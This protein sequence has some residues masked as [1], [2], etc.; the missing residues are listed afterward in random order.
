VEIDSSSAPTIH[1]HAL[2]EPEL[3]QKL[4]TSRAGLTPAQAAERLREF[5]PNVLPT[6]KPPSPFVI[7]LRQLLSP[8]IYILIAAGVLAIVMGDL[9]D[10]IFILGVVV[11]NAALGTFQE[12]KA[13]QSAASLQK[14]L[15]VTARVRRGQQSLEISADELVPGDWVFLE[16]GARVPADLRLLEANNLAADEAFLTGESVA[17]EKR[18]GVLAEDSPVSD[19]R[20]MAFAGSLITTGRGAGVVVAT[21]IRTEVGKIAKTVS[22][23]EAAKSPLVIRM[24][25]FAKQVSY[26][27]VGACVLL[28]AV[29]VGRGMA[30]LDV[31]FLA[32][33]LAVSSIP[34]GLPVAM[35]VALSIATLRM[36]K[37]NVIVRR[38]TAVE[39]LGSCTYIA[40]DKTGTLT[41][42]KQTVQTVWLPGVGVLPVNTG[43]TPPDD[44]AARLRELCRISLICNEAVAKKQNG[45]WIFSGDAV[46]VAYWEWALRLGVDLETV[47]A[48]K[49]KGEIPFESE[50]AYSAAFFED[51]GALAVAVKGAPEVLLA[52][53]R[54]GTFDRAEVEK[55]LHALTAS[56]HRVMAIARGLSPL[57]PTD[58]SLGEEDLPELELM[59]LTG[60][61]D[62]PRPEVRPAV[63]KCQRAGIQVA[64]VT[65]DH[66]LTALAIAREVGIPAKEDEVVTGKQLADIGT[67]EVPLFIDT[68]KKAR[69]FARVSPMQKLQIVEALRKLGHFVA[70]TGDGVNDAPALKKA[71][72]GVAM[73]SGTDVTKETASIIVTDDNFASIEAGVEEGRFAY[74]NI[75]KVTYLLI[76]TGFAEVVLFSFA[77]LSGLPMPLLPVQLLW[78]NL[79][80]NGMQHIGLAFEAGEPGAMLRPPRDPQEGI[81]NPLMI[82]QVITAGTV[83]AILAFIN[84]YVLVK[85][86]GFNEF[87]A[88]DRLLLLMVLIENY[89]VFNCRSEYVSAFRVPFR[90]NRM[91]ILGVL[92]AQGIHILAMFFPP[93][94]RVL[95]VA[96]VSL[97][98]W[99]VPFAMA[100]GVLLAMEVFKVVKHG[101]AIAW[102]PPEAA[103]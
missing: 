80:T 19:R 12:W 24:E 71:N 20:N 58:R 48:V 57:A 62:P 96:P 92:A 15:R 33:A 67:P 101:R 75:R 64:M 45:Q 60:L 42:N 5:G 99:L 47:L 3:L 55:Q 21:G 1:W 27:V 30:V 87:D 98:E 56:G 23:E 70:V 79:V 61:I 10:A 54:P 37:R 50:R 52:R 16:S 72:I 68:V 95:H 83:M 39:G 53:C 31:L 38:L 8:L 103:P 89:H 17:A 14:L 102:N 59:G 40:S 76:A 90:R 2:E 6:R 44:A 74:D 91:L 85:V 88:R 43:E 9:T 49:R 63:E 26:A 18:T 82:Q 25:I 94:Q 29:A 100:G 7:F 46:D 32:V 84:F 22:S 77:L 78:L 93:L 97:T 51:G 4:E 73:G 69:V 36:A 86:M 13:E 81:F 65:G 41:I 11:L 28:G 35:T 66:P 34:E